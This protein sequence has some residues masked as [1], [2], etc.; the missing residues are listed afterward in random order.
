MTAVVFSSVF[1]VLVLVVVKA[2][3]PNADAEKVIPMRITRLQ[4]VVGDQCDQVAEDCDNDAQNDGNH[5]NYSPQRQTH[6]R[7]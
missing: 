4:P 7:R 5:Q 3:L 2:G 1:L 6:P